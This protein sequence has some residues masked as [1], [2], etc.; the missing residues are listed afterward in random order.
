MKTYLILDISLFIFIFQTTISFTTEKPDS[1][2]I[3]PLCDKL[4]SILCDMLAR[5]SPFSPQEKN[6]DLV[7]QDS[8]F[9]TPR[10]QMTISIQT[11]PSTTTTT[12]GFLEIQRISFGILR[13]NLNMTL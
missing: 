13:I 4:P 10:T 2:K 1:L 11:M 3:N 6:L 8:V 7:K 9:P 5:P 12:K